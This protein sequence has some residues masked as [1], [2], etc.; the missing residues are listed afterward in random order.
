[1]TVT[2]VMLTTHSLMRTA[3]VLIVLWH[4]GAGELFSSMAGIERLVYA[5][6][7]TVHA[8]REYIGDEQTRLEQLSAFVCA[9][10]AHAHSFSV[11]HTHTCQ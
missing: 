10:V 5:H 7:L 3:T 8:L 1:V 9:R 11:M 6:E 4:T 2:A